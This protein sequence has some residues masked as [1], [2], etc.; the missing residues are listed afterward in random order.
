MQ[1]YVHL[2]DNNRRQESYVRTILSGN[3]QFYVILITDAGFTVDQKNKPREVKDA[4]TLGEITDECGCFWLHTSTTNEEFVLVR[5]QD[6][7][8]TKAAPDPDDPTAIEN[9]IKFVRI[10][11]KVM[12]MIHAAL[13]QRFAILNQ[14]FLFYA[15]VLPLHASYQ[16]GLNSSYQYI[17]R[18]SFIVIV[19]SSLLNKFHPGFGITYLDDNEHHAAADRLLAR[20][21]TR[22]PLLHDIW[23]PEVQ[24]EKSGGLWVETNFGDFHSHG[25][26]FPRL[27]PQQINPIA[28]DIVSGPAAILHAQSLCTYMGQL[29]IRAEKLDLDMDET[30]EY[31]SCFP[32]EWKVEYQKVETANNSAPAW[33][34]ES[35]FGRWRNLCFVRSK[36]PPTF[37]SAT[38]PANFHYAVIGFSQESSGSLQLLPPYDK[39]VMWRC[40]RCAALNGSMSMCRHLAA[41]LMGLSFKHEYRSTFRRVNLLNTVADQERQSLVILPPITQSQDIPQLIPRRSRDWR[42]ESSNLYATG[43]TQIARSRSTPPTQPRSVAASLSS[44]VTLPLS[45]APVSSPAAT[46]AT[47][48]QQS[49]PSAASSLSRPLLPTSSLSGSSSSIAV[50]RST[51][52]TCSST[53]RAVSSSPGAA[54]TV[55]TASRR[56]PVP[57]VLPSPPSTA[58]PVS[59]LAPVSSRVSVSQ[60]T[61]QGITF[62]YLNLAKSSY[63]LP[64]FSIS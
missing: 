30:Q 32:D 56:A 15:A 35:L 47:V 62:L 12:E 42:R 41:L 24:F 29:T 50:S 46:S 1:R 9:T 27:T 26:N 10:F 60:P 55:V 48:T 13:K 19:C 3:D 8:I 43:S 33:W 37:K 25:L 7:K 21:F 22:N 16:S 53:A 4:K 57:H 6:G 40:C 18:L 17:C 14:K 39:I 61:R 5:D 44:L 63:F 34:D 31:L 49:G 11:R 59:Q 23:P 2:E 36:I 52:P 64:K 51:A 28:I 20:L 58:S 45:S 38:Q 54:G